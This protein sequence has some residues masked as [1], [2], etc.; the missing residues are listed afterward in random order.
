MLEK[1]LTLVFLKYDYVSP[2]MLQELQELLGS[3][4]ASYQWVIDNVPHWRRDPVANLRLYCYA[5]QH[6]I[7]YPDS[8]YMLN[9]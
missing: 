6:K 7:D 2:A 9:K 8:E 3:K 1:Y 5:L 4:N